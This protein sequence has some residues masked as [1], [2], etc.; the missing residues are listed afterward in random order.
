MKT[1]RIRG[2]VAIAVAGLLT[3]SA[4]ACGDDDDKGS[5]ATTTT[6][7]STSATTGD[8]TGATTAGSSGGDASSA[9][10]EEYLAAI[11]GQFTNSGPDSLQM[12]DEQASCVAPK[13]LDV[14]TVDKLKE[15][16][17]SPA[18][19]EADTQNE[20][21]ASLGLSDGDA[22]KMYAAYADCDVDVRAEFARSVT[23]SLEASPDVEDCV[24]DAISDD[25]LQR[26]FVV[27]ITKGDAGL[28][29]DSDLSN[30]LFAALGKCAPTTTTG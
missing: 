27:S 23:A 1:M 3:L 8:T 25:L 5:D 24:N 17:I 21:L 9:T 16:G 20:K 30:E 29:A 18:D 4:A 10:E 19:I 11:E 2:V 22:E 28:D 15:K 12:T 7:A 13:W 14:I 6:A 26:I